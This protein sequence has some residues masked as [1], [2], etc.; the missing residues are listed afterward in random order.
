MCLQYAREAKKVGLPLSL[1]VEVM[2]RLGLR[3]ETTPVSNSDQFGL[4]A[5][6]MARSNETSVETQGFRRRR[7]RNLFSVE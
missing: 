5:F 4:E 6:A 7:F 2:S 3:I 1:A